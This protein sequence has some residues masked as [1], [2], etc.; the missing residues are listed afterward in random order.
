MIN[1]TFNTRKDMIIKLQQ[2][3]VKTKLKLYKN[4]SNY[5]DEMK[6]GNFRYEED[7]SP[8]NVQV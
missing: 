2:L 5:Y 7:T 3:K 6:I 8:K 4:L 1:T